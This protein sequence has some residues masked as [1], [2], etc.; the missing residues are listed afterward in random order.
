MKTSIKMTRARWFP[1]DKLPF[2]AASKLG[3]QL[4]LNDNKVESNEGA[5]MPLQKA[6]VPFFFF[7]FNTH[8]PC[9]CACLRRVAAARVAMAMALLHLGPGGADHPSPEETQSGCI[10]G[11]GR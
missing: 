9:V 10:G 8:S 4:R 2:C 3:D 5:E 6:F 1:C 11:A 7:L